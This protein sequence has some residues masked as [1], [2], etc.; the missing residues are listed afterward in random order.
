MR[1]A[2]I[3]RNLNP[4]SIPAVT[5]RTQPRSDPSSH[6]PLTE[7]TEAREKAVK[8]VYRALK[9]MLQREYGDAVTP[10][11]M[12][13][14]NPKLAH[15]APKEAVESLKRELKSY[16]AKTNPFD[17]PMRQSEHVIDWWIALQKDE[18]CSVLGVS[19]MRSISSSD[20]D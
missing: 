2:P 20:I 8:R 15:L 3:F 18:L 9:G 11:E 5:L 4:L 10:E 13:V 16:A 7:M 1:D 19:A 6:V 14:R 12:K 17:R